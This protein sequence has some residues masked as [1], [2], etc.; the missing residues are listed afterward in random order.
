MLPSGPKIR[1]KQHPNANFQ[2]NVSF[3]KPYRITGQL[4]LNQGGTAMDGPA[5]VVFNE[6]KGESLL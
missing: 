4:N 3:I 2:I 1:H 5:G 6:K